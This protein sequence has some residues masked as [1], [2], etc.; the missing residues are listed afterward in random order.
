[1]SIVVQK[2]YFVQSCPASGSLSLPIPS[3]ILF[4]DPWGK[5]YVDALLWLSTPLKLSCELLC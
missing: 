4:S 1:M 5:V 3:L 2:T